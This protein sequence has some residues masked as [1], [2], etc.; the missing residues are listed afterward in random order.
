MVEYTIPR[1]EVIANRLLATICGALI[2][3]PLA[4]NSRYGWLLVLAFGVLGFQIGKRYGASRGFM[5]FSFVCVVVLA[6]LVTFRV[7]NPP[8]QAEPN[9]LQEVPSP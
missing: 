8:Y 2:S 4:M 7:V 1:Y 9:A 5:Y 6:W 3:L